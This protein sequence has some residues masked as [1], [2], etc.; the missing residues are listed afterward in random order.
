MDVGLALGIV[1]V[2]IFL[3]IIGGFPLSYIFGFAALSILAMVGTVDFRMVMPSAMKLLLS[4]ALLALPMYILVGTL[5][6]A[7]VLSSRLVEWINAVLGRGKSILGATAVL[8]CT[9]FGAISGS[10]LSAVAAV[11]KILI[12]Q[13]EQYAY[14]REYMAGVIACSSLIAMLIPPSL[15][16]I[17]FGVTAEINVAMCFLAAAVPGLIVTSFYLVITF[18]LTRKVSSVSRPPRT[19][20][21]P[22]EILRSTKRAS[23]GLVLP[24]IILGGIYGGFFTPTEAAG[25]AVI[26][27]LF[28]GFVIHREF[29]PKFTDSLL[30]AGK[31]IGSI[32]VLLFFLF[33]FSQALIWIRVPQAVQSFV[34]ATVT[35]KTGFLVMASIIIFFLGMVIEGSAVVILVAIL[36]LP[37]ATAYGINPYHFAAVAIVN[38]GVG[39]LTP[40]VAPILYFAAT[41]GDAR[42]SFFPPSKY[43]KTVVTYL[44]FGHLPV[45]ILVMF[46]PALSLF[47][48]NLWIAIM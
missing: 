11:G 10:G 48:P 9:I 44:L 4:Y 25:V 27:I 21:R 6:S 47:L 18:F 30:E 24:V 1:V 19:E 16:M 35:T 40:P 7:G 2:F 31:L 43:I 32:G 14:D 45:L 17:L 13:A 5:M 15:P 46:I 20:R 22:M 28:D 38:T 8:F 12:P 29:I 42:V 3:L 41:V 39:N 37:A 26:W 23:T 34:L 36:L 33:T